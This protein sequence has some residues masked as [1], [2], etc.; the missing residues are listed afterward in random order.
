[1]SATVLFPEDADLVLDDVGEPVATATVPASAGVLGYVQE[2]AQLRVLGVEIPDGTFVLF[3]KRGALVLGQ[4]T[5][6]TVGAGT[7][8]ARD[9]RARGPVDGPHGIFDAWRVVPLKAVAA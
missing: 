6:V 1:M 8:A 9:F 3:V 7:A 2:A 5:L 4:D